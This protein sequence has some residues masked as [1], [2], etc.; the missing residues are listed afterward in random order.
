[1]GKT[2]PIGTRETLRDGTIIEVADVLEEGSCKGCLFN[3]ISDC[4]AP[5]YL[6]EC[7]SAFRTDH[8]DIIFKKIGHI[9]G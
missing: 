8:V 1:M 6:C 3:N 2:W 7:L 4:N 5:F 9:G